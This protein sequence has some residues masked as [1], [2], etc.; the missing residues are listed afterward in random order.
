MKGLFIN[1]K[2]AQDSFYESGLMV[3]NNLKLSNQFT[4]D[5]IEIDQASR[6]IPLEYQFYLFD[7]QYWDRE[8]QP[9]HW[10]GQ[11]YS[12]RIIIWQLAFECQG[13]HIGAGRRWSYL[14]YDSPIRYPN[15]QS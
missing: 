8:V 10:T 12:Q 6:Q 7:K 15:H 14:V 11:Y 2:K 9:D 5:Y 4:L 13:L 1:N 3:F